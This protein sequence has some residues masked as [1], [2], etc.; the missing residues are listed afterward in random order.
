MKSQVF[1][2]FDAFAA[3]VRDVDSKMLL[4]NPQR[5]TWSIDSVEVNGIDLQIGRL[6][7]GNIAQGQ[8]RADGFML[9]LPL[10]AGI[11]Y[12]ANGN[13]LEKHSC[14]ILE[15]GGEFC[16]STKIEHDWCAVFI[17]HKILKRVDEN[18]DSFLDSIKKT[19]R[20][21]A[22]DRQS[23]NQLQS[24]VGQLMNAAATY[25]EFES[26]P[27]AT[28]AAA[29]LLKVASGFVGLQSTEQLN[30]NGRPKISR[31]QIIRNAMEVIE[32][33]AR[34]P[35]A[36]GDLTAAANVSERT[37]RTAFQEYFGMGPVRYLM[38]NQLH[39]VHLALKLADREEFTVGQVLMDHGEYA[40][41]R[42]ASRHKRLYGELPS[43]TLQKRRIR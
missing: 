4:R 14:A 39:R 31:D 35:V 17:P 26:T 8:L 40:F 41:S 2:D 15:P 36:L 21:S 32:Q 22:P 18:F 13:L 30:G 16:I 29:N 23:A 37:L 25:S 7:S 12:T 34:A 24:I 20:V 28:N 3:S 42:F 1:F 11:Q 43:E 5:R 38:L 6:G 9:Y 27:A 10:T 33:N 19:C